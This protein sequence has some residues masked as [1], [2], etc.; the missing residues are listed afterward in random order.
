MVLVRV[1]IRTCICYCKNQNQSSFCLLVAELL[2][3]RQ[4]LTSAAPLFFFWG[5]AKKYISSFFAF[6]LVF[7][8]PFWTLVIGVVLLVDF[9]G[10][11]TKNV[12]VLIFMVYLLLLAKF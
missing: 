8:P 6:A 5:P 10:K 11:L 7:F 9:W 12:M 3:N 4:S 2:K 1:Q